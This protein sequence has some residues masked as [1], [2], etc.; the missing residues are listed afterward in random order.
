MGGTIS[1]N[2]IPRMVG[3]STKWLRQGKRN[4]SVDLKPEIGDFQTFIK[5]TKAY[6][7]DHVALH[8]LPQGQG[9]L[10][11]QMGLKC[12]AKM[13]AK[14][15]MKNSSKYCEKCKGKKEETLSHVMLVCEGHARARSPLI[16]IINSLPKAEQTRLGKLNSKGRL[17]N[18]ILGGDTPKVTKV[19][20]ECLNEMLKDSTR[21]T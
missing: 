21:Q 9:K 19:A 13:R 2:R 20:M 5:A 8:P 17:L 11:G 15:K 3:K 14:G 12:D 18:H 10:P 7:G 16:G 4:G 1:T 6:I